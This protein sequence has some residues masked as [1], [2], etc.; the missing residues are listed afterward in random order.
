MWAVVLGVVGEGCL[1]LKGVLVS[2]V[3]DVVGCCVGGVAGCMKESVLLV[4]L[5]LLFISEVIII[6]KNIESAGGH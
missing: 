5:S 6:H 1:V 3:G 2:V 4:S